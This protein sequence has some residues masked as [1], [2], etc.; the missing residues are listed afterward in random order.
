MIMDMKEI[1]T[2]SLLYPFT[3]FFKFLVLG[4]LLIFATFGVILSPMALYFPVNLSVFGLAFV[5]VLYGYLI[6][7]IDSS[8]HGFD[9]LPDF[10]NVFG[11][12]V[13]GL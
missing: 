2:G 10:N 8:F 3:G 1:M 4:F 12:F 7:V 11:L 9:K 13:E 6:R 5:F